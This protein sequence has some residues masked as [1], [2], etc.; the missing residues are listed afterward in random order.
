MPLNNFVSL[1]DRL[2]H[3]RFLDQVDGL[4]PL[5]PNTGELRAPSTMADPDLMLTPRVN[6]MRELTYIGPV[7]ENLIC[8]ICVSAFVEPIQTK[9]LHTFCLDC[10]RQAT[11][12]STSCPSCRTELLLHDD[13]DSDM[14]DDEEMEEYMRLAHAQQGMMRLGVRD[15]PILIKNMLD[16]LMVKCSYS[17]AGC[18]LIL[19][20]SQISTHVE[21]Y[22]SFPKVLCPTEGCPLRVRR[23]DAKKGCLHVP[24][25]C[26]GCGYKGLKIKEEVRAAYILHLRLC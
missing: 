26:E 13:E 7:N 23:K 21:R 14:S 4:P 18:D 12:H 17:E 1:A 10:L 6:N 11:E 5:D 8:P 20:R 2:S 9:C 24:W 3:R 16:D 19:P 22:C 25:T 15:A